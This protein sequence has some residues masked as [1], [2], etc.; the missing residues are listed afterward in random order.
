MLP[1]NTALPP[2]RSGSGYPLVSDAARQPSF[3]ADLTKV[4]WGPGH[5]SVKD[6]LNQY[7]RGRTYQVNWLVEKACCVM[8]HGKESRSHMYWREIS[9]DVGGILA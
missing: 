5:G 7:L 4:F 1:E 8:L 2:L 9:L 3:G 6:L